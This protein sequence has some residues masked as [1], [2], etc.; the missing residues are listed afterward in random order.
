MEG[1]NTLIKI[2]SALDQLVTSPASA[3]PNTS[4]LVFGLAESVI[5]LIWCLS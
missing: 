3:P 5:T 2:S 4:E 1:I